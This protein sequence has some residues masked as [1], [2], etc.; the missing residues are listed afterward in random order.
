MPVFPLV[1]ARI[2][3][4]K[5]CPGNVITSRATE[6]VFKDKFPSTVPATHPATTAFPPLVIFAALGMLPPSFART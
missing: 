4:V 2:A 6:P 1:D 3:S 5:D